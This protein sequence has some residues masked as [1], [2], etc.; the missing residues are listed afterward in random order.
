MSVA[1]GDVINQPIMYGPTKQLIAAAK[2]AQPIH[3]KKHVFIP[4]NILSYLPAPRFC[5]Q[6][7]AAAVPSVGMVCVAILL[8][9]DAAV[10]AATTCEPN[11]LTAA[12]KII[13]PIAVIE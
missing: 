1:V 13:V 9:L 2:T 6:Y 4:L 12:W 7:V 11:T 10:N 3:M 8:T 5:P